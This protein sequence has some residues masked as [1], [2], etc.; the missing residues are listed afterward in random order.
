MDD[1]TDLWGD[2][3]KM[4]AIGKKLGGFLNQVCRARLPE[5]ETEYYGSRWGFELAERERKGGLDEEKIL[6]EMGEAWVEQHRK[7]P[8]EYVEMR[9][10]AT[11]E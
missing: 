5:G 2:M 3:K 10:K 7:P 11:E 1:L 4:E 6:E 9:L 8:T